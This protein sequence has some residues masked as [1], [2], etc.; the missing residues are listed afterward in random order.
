[1]VIFR[2]ALTESDSNKSL[3]NAWFQALK[4]QDMRLETSKGVRDKASVFGIGVKFGSQETQGSVQTLIEVPSPTKK[5]APLEINPFSFSIAFQL[6]EAFFMG[7]FFNQSLSTW[8]L[9]RRAVMQGL[10]LQD[11]ISQVNL[12]NRASLNFLAF[13]NP[14]LPNFLGRHRC[15][16]D[17]QARYRPDSF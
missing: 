11:A 3:S 17:F 16:Q 7:S 9:L 12:D 4:S 14:R 5:Q 2:I 1:M 13:L 10:S 8:Y 6:Y 15:S